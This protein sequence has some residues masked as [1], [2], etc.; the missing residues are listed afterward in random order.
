[1][2]QRCCKKRIKKKKEYSIVMKNVVGF[3]TFANQL[4]KFTEK[5]EVNVV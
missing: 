2:K 3:L 4:K 1:M 5:M